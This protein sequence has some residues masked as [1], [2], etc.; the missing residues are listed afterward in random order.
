VDFLAIIEEDILPNLASKGK[1]EIIG[2]FF[3]SKF[4]RR[5]NQK[6]NN[7]LNY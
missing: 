3:I 6:F 1:L 5:V 2:G 7:I 4:V